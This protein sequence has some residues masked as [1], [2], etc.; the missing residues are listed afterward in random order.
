M[1]EVYR[2]RDSRLDRQVAIK[3]LPAEFTSDQ[4]RVRRF[5]QEAKAAS[6]LNHP[7]IITI[8]EIGE[9]ESGRF[10]AMEFVQGRTLRELIGQPLSS[11]SLSSVGSQ[12]AKALAVAHASGIV[13]R[14]IKPE[15]IVVRPDGYVKVLDFGLARLAP[16]T[17]T[18]PEA[19][20]A[21]QT[22]PG[23]LLG[24]MAYM[25]P[26]QAS[27][28]AVTPA[29]DVF[30]LGIVVYELA[31]GQ[32]PFRAGTM[33]GLLQAI[34]S[35]LPPP[36]S[37]FN[38]A[39]PAALDDVI[40]RMLEKEAKR[41]PTAVE[42]ERVLSE[43]STSSIHRPAQAKPERHTVGREK[44]RAELRNAFASV[45]TGRGLL[46]CVA[47]EPGIGKTTLVEDF[48]AE[49]QAQARCTLARG[50]CSERLAGTEAYLPLLEA[51]ENLMQSGSNAAVVQVMKQRAP[52]WYA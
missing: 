47:G 44:E 28:E 15:N 50:R 5:V 32:R 46:L 3:V 12:V 41:R 30:A 36:P 52:T 21:H 38:P 42:V 2:A 13:H 34:V 17:T 10:I 11:D 16:A 18:D 4:D 26:E 33:L 1:G 37:A 20:T 25:S 7:N 31:T 19:T 27:G 43:L 35:H 22:I 45:L 9:S 29:T 14:D 24:T 8:Y 6:A 23:V 40:R 39:V 48:F 51:L 49:L